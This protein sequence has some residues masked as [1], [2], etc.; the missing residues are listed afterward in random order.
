MKTIYEKTAVITNTRN[1]ISIDAEVDNIRENA[2]GE[3]ESLD[4]FI[5]TNKIHMRWN[6]KVYVG[7]AGG[8]QFTS[9]GPKQR[10]V[11]VRGR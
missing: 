7:N 9:L 8:M 6:G 10:S 4:A 3:P 11:S 2:K 1:E 5:A